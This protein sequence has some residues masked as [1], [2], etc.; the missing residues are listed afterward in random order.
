MTSADL[1][2]VAARLIE[3]SGQGI[4]SVFDLLDHPELESF[5]R[6]S[7]IQALIA[8]ADRKSRMRVHQLCLATGTEWRDVPSLGEVVVQV[9]AATQVHF[10]L[11]PEPFPSLLSWFGTGDSIPD[12]I[13][14]LG[15]RFA[16]L[17]PHASGLD[18]LQQL[19]VALRHWE[20]SVPFAAARV[21]ECSAA[22]LASGVL[23]E[24][25]AL[26]AI[27][28]RCA[29]HLGDEV[30]L[31]PQDLLRR[32]DALR[33][34]L[35][36]LAATAQTTVPE[37]AS[38]LRGLRMRMPAGLDEPERGL[39]SAALSLLDSP[40]PTAAAHRSYRGN[41][42]LTNDTRLDVYLTPLA[43]TTG[44]FGTP[45]RPIVSQGTAGPELRLPLADLAAERAARLS[46]ALPLPGPTGEVEQSWWALR[47]AVVLRSDQPTPTASISECLPKLSLRFVSEGTEIGRVPLRIVDDFA[48]YRATIPERSTAGV[49]VALDGE[50][51]LDWIAIAEQVDRLIGEGLL[52][53]AA[54]GGKMLAELAR[55]ALPLPGASEHD[56][57][58]RGLAALR[59]AKC[60]AL[61]DRADAAAS[62]TDLSNYGRRLAPSLAEQVMQSPA[63]VLQRVA[64]VVDLPTLRGTLASRVMDIIRGDPIGYQLEDVKELAALVCAIDRTLNV[65]RVS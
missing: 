30:A 65:G 53:A 12:G 24:A 33:D 49:V 7:A 37:A 26:G 1:R 10:E 3:S 57:A 40:A 45:F 20:V 15:H 62:A 34:L 4:D 42:T 23:D 41:S 54:Y 17:A 21:I 43:M 63:D 29:E 6:A 13:T 27:A 39:P 5:E 52:A 32:L 8:A 19:A 51:A 46:A 55:P 14:D 36:E 9:D 16:G 48:E 18:E 28:S 47:M 64:A 25:P 35:S 11:H 50:P 44:L 56:D 61:L 2:E 38:A 59:S 60:M 22:V 58:S 31:L